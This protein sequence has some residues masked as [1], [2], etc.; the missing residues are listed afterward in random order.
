M[1]IEQLPEA[2][3]PILR[4]MLMILKER[5]MSAFVNSL[6]DADS[7]ITVDLE[8]FEYALAIEHL[9]VIGEVAYSVLVQLMGHSNKQV[10][11]YAL[12]TI[13]RINKAGP[14]IFDDLW[15]ALSEK[16]GYRSTWAYAALEFVV[17]HH[18]DDAIID[19]LLGHRDIDLEGSYAGIALCGKT[20]NIKV[21]QP[22]LEQLLS[23]HDFSVQ[24]AIA[25]ALGDL[26]EMVLPYVQALSRHE[27]SYICFA[28]VCILDNISHRTALP[29]LL[30]QVK[31]PDPDI[32]NREMLLDAISRYAKKFGTDDIIPVLID[33][34]NQPD[35]SAMV[36]TIVIQLLNILNAADAVAERVVEVYLWNA[37]AANTDDDEHTELAQACLEIFTDEFVTRSQSIFKNWATH[38]NDLVR[39]QVSHYLNPEES[40]NG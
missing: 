25:Y 7:I 37:I 8:L 5:D 40:E 30:E 32:E 27:D 33:L 35:D 1:A 10:R 38:E 6:P 39:K 11:N 12:R 26:G 22:L 3:L 28:I 29:L 16:E 2:N 23:T 17:I 15:Q 19:F 34:L 31:N 21:V 14:V 36:H 24:M 20:G 18:T 9:E 4:A 13:N